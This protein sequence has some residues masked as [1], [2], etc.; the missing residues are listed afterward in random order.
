MS[1]IEI[2]GMRP[3]DEYFVSTCGHVD[4]SDEVDASGRRRLAWLRR[5]QSRGL[6]VKVAV[7]EGKIVGFIYAMPIEVCPWG[8]LGADLIAVPCLSVQKQ[9][10]KNG[11]GGSLLT[12]VEEK[13]REDGGK[14][15]ATTAYQSMWFMPVAFFERMGYELVG[16]EGK[17]TVLWKA[18]DPTSEPPRVL[19][20]HYEFERVSGRVIVDL[21]FSSFCQTSDLEAQR[22]R[23]VVAEFGDDVVLKEHDADD[24]D[25]LEKYQLYRA[26]YVNGKEIDWGYTMPRDGIRDEIAKAVE[27][28]R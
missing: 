10:W 19:K 1:H 4:E 7:V 11:I 9:W 15:V 22:V 14:G 12:A 23:E 21:F 17:A 2:T 27:S 26:L 8:P 25:V 5:M 24:R 18:F 28:V 20:P 13:T 16:S 3:E 6:Y